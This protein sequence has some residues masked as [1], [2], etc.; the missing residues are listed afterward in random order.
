MNDS[1][2][3]AS[4]PPSLASLVERDILQELLADKKSPNTRRTYA[5]SLRDFFQTIT[6]DKTREPTIDLVQEFLSL[7]RFS[8]ISLV[9]KYKGMLVNKG[10]SPATI[11]VRLCAIASLVNYARKNRKMRLQFGRRRRT[12][13]AKLSRYDGN[14]TGEF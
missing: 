3:L 5:K 11:N 12:E 1:L 8:A 6:G 9:L 10:L 7:D 13:G 2:K 4:T 14:R